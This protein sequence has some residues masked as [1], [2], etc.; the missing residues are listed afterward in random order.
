[1]LAV[2]I[3]SSTSFNCFWSLLTSFA[4]D[5]CT[6]SNL[7]YE[8]EYKRYFF[9]VSPV[10]LTRLEALWRQCTCLMC[11]LYSHSTWS[12][13]WHN[14]CSINTS[15]LQACSLMLPCCTLAWVLHCGL[16]GARWV[17]WTRTLGGIVLG[18]RGLG[19]FPRISPF[20]FMIFQPLC[21]LNS[22]LVISIWYFQA[23]P[24]WLPPTVQRYNSKGRPWSYAGK[25]AV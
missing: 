24:V 21:H 7:C 19:G 13:A 18:S 2:F 23:C 4:L 15:S 14:K 6:T 25:S 17:H 10:F 20:T 11:H 5:S 8:I 1:M 9:C 22:H 12:S 3:L 16:L